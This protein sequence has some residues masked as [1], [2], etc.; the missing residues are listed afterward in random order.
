MIHWLHKDGNLQ[1]NFVTH[2][3][4]YGPRKVCNRFMLVDSDSTAECLLRP[5]GTCAEVSDAFLF[6]FTSTGARKRHWKNFEFEI[7]PRYAAVVG[8]VRVCLSLVT[9]Q[10]RCVMR[11]EAGRQTHALYNL[12]ISV[13][14]SVH[15]RV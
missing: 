9:S 1:W 8:K 15:A 13:P 12:Q 5:A 2:G 10:T 6:A 3:L 7:S 14:L 11:E 4:A